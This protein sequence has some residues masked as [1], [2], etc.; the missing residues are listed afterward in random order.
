MS[1][2]A[3]TTMV[4]DAG[5]PRKQ[6]VVCRIMFLIGDKLRISGCR[7]AALALLASSLAY[8]AP[9]TRVVER[10][11]DRDR[12]ITCAVKSGCRHVYDMAAVLV[13][14]DLPRFEDYMSWIMRESDVDVRFVFVRGTGK[15]SIG[16]FAADAVDELRI[17]GKT[18][19]ERGVLL[20]YDV[21]GQRLKVEVGYGLEGYFPDAFVSYLVNDHARMFFASGDLSVGLRL[22]L[23]LLQHRI[24][25]AVI[26]NAFDPRAVKAVEAGGYLSGGAG[27]S[28]AVPL[29]S[30]IVT[31]AVTSMS[32]QE[33]S[34]YLARES[35]EQTYSAY[36]DWLAGT[37][38][39][40]E[41]DLFTPES[42][43]YLL[44]FPLTPAYRHFILF[45]EYG[46]SHRIVR[47]GDHAVLYFTGTPFVSPHF[48]VN[49]AG[50]WR[51]DMA[52]EV[53][54]TAEH[55]GG[56]YTWTYRGVGDPYTTAISDLLVSMNGYRRFKD[57]DNRKLVIRGAKGL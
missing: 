12:L 10:V 54:N 13:P 37:K 16:E 47:R 11:A 53:R 8:A 30:A 55:V 26:G 46:K 34:R 36:L 57:G 40:P 48:F 21:A 4:C 24:R 50:R 49:E 5:Q 2:L 15:R 19:E 38:F 27:V 14:Q 35:P 44:G 52:A 18:R 23:R 1:D 28:A 42:R 56:V 45:G 43:R 33:K 41:V 29:S 32:A 6:N 22:L 20:L 39:D 51:I 31:G 25:E 3:R 9:N 7:A 17:G